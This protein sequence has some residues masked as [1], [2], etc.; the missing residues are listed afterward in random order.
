MNLILFSL[1]NFKQ[2]HKENSS[3]Q[4]YIAKVGMKQSPFC[5][6][7]YEN[8]PFCFLNSTNIDKSSIIQRIYGENIREINTN[9]QYFQDSSKFL[10]CKME[11][12]DKIRNKLNESINDRYWMKINV[13]NLYHFVQFGS[14]SSNGRRIFSHY[15]F[16]FIHYNKKLQD[17]SIAPSDPVDIESSSI[18]FYF[19]SEWQEISKKLTMDTK[20]S[21][22]FLNV[23][24]KVHFKK[25][26]MICLILAALIM[27]VRNIYVFY[28]KDNSNELKDVP[29]VE[30]FGFSFD[31][32]R[33]LAADVYRT[34]VLSTVLYPAVGA[35]IQLIFIILLQFIINYL[36]FDRLWTSYQLWTTFVLSTLTGPISS[37]FTMHCAS[38]YS[39][40]GKILA[41]F[42]PFILP[43]SMLI[44]AYILNIG[45][46]IFSSTRILPI[47]SI[48]KLLIIIIMISSISAIV[49]IN[50]YEIIPIPKLYNTPEPAIYPSNIPLLG[51][52]V[53]IPLGLVIGFLVAF[54][55][56][57]EL[58]YISYSIIQ[59]RKISYWGFMI[60]KSVMILMSTACI[61]AIGVFFLLV[62][63]N[64]NWQWFAFVS[65]ASSGIYL[66]IYCIWIFKSLVNE[67]KIIIS[68]ETSIITVFIG[69][70]FAMINGCCGYIASS[71]LVHKM[72]ED[73][74]VD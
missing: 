25:T 39:V 4:I 9:F 32:F 66:A 40:N 11:I 27:F 23:M 7:R 47:F 43:V 70:T 1:I 62:F 68:F 61:T 19:S 5:S 12:D 54:L 74:K 16:T 52:L 8:L 6:I 26:I 35:G 37:Y 63:Q 55:D 67:Q 53:N 58:T 34:P 69:L 29:M 59:M 71:V 30:T 51:K 14:A 31:N 36:F 49:G 20:H 38:V 73:R 13:E 2:I 10:N 41:S 28:I 72:Y 33:E 56:G 15:H 24:F 64:Y 60:I 22:Y 65:P 21:Q 45:S 42:S 18:S 44:I 57:Q 50:M 17:F 46:V 48:I 3:L